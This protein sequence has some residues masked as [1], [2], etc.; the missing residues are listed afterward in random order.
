MS[1]EFQAVAAL[2]VVAAAAIWLVLRAL[3]RRRAP[4][5]GHGCGCP[6]KTG[7]KKSV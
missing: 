5:C 3:A 4:G 2:A 1:P 7:L 6:G